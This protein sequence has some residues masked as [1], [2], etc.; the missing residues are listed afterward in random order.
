MISCPECGEDTRVI[1]SRG[2]G[3][4]QIRKRICKSCRH[5]FYTS[6]SDIKDSVGAAKLQA[7]EW[8]KKKEKNEANRLSHI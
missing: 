1:N 8:D 3:C 5:I 2:D 4:E 6:E 7:F